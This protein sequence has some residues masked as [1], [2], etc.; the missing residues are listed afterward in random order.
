MIMLNFIWAWCFWEAV[1]VKKFFPWHPFVFCKTTNHKSYPSNKTWYSSFLITPISL[2]D[3]S[4]VY[5]FYTPQLSLF[6]LKMIVNIE[7]S[8]C[9]SLNKIVSLIFWCILSFTQQTINNIQFPWI[10]MNLDSSSF[11]HLLA[12]SP[13]KVT[14]FI[15]KRSYLKMDLLHA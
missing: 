6:F 1:M 11:S 13:S 14:F 8:Y 7:C 10:V 2:T 3:D 12:M 5:L 4:F 15:P 9:N